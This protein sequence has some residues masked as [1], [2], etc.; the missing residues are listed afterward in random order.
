MPNVTTCTCGRLYEAG[1]EEQ[2]NEPDRRCP[3]C[4]GPRAAARYEH[5]NHRTTWPDDCS[6]CDAAHPVFPRSL[7]HLGRALDEIEKDDGT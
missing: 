1:S 5:P 4:R 7:G 3:W 6:I 2:A